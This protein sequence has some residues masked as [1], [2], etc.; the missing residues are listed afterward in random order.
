MNHRIEKLS[1]LLDKS[2]NQ[3]KAAC[4]SGISIKCENSMNGAN[5][6]NLCSPTLKAKPFLM[7]KFKRLQI[8]K[9]SCDSYRETLTNSTQLTIHQRI[10][11]KQRPFAC[12]QCQKCFSSKMITLRTN[13]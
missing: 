12:D 3:L 4:L 9:F 13:Q 6:D 2:E 7:P 5:D 11:S 8:E 10:H 1:T